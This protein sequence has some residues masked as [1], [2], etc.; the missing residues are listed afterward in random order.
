M[1]DV[2]GV[3][4]FIINSWMIFTFVHP[5][6][7]TNTRYIRTVCFRVRHVLLVAPGLNE[8]PPS[9]SCGS[10]AQVSRQ[11]VN[12]V[13]ASRIWHATA[14]RA[15]YEIDSEKF[16]RGKYRSHPVR[17]AATTGYHGAA[18]WNPAPAGKSAPEYL[19][20]RAMVQLT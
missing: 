12:N 19:G 15:N 8:L 1:T 13:A 17:T 16:A 9:Q 3:Y 4:R 11:P 14:F 20:G 7:D 6:V 5:A 2:S 18:A 10:N